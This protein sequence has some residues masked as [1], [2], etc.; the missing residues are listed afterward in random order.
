MG[1]HHFIETSIAMASRSVSTIWCL[2]VA[3]NANVMSLGIRRNDFSTRLRF[4]QPFYNPQID[5]GQILITYDLGIEVISK[6]SVNIVNILK[7]SIFSLLA[8]NNLQVP[9]TNLKSSQAVTVHCPKQEFRR[10]WVWARPCKSWPPGNANPTRFAC[11]TGVG[12]ASW[13]LCEKQGMQIRGPWCMQIRA[14]CPS[15]K[16]PRCI[17]CTLCSAHATGRDGTFAKDVHV[18]INRP[19]W[20]S[21][22]HLDNP[23]HSDSAS[24]ANTQFLAS[25]YPIYSDVLEVHVWCSCRHAFGL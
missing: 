13:F 14:F 25:Q 10:K 11:T 17:G 4:F 2:P 8:Q 7:E 3:L 16:T 5:I 20:K 19:V 21:K 24:H 15:E 23:N 18:L 1:I 6:Q 9:E 22:Q 12:F